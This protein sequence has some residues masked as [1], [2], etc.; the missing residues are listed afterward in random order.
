MVPYRS[1]LTSRVQVVWIRGAERLV[2]SNPTGANQ[3]FLHPFFST[4]KMTFTKALARKQPKRRG[5]VMMIM[6][7]S[8]Q[9]FGG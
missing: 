4:I 5:S 9:L 6:M 3:V 8:Y 2:G 1:G 7:M